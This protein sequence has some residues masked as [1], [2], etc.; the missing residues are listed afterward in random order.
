MS[1]GCGYSPVPDAGSFRLHWQHRKPY[2][3]ENIVMMCLSIDQSTNQSVE[4]PSNLG[5][6]PAG[7]CFMPWFFVCT[8]CV[9]PCHSSSN[10]PFAFALSCSSGPDGS[11]SA[12]HQLA[13]AFLLLFIESLDGALSLMLS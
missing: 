1:G 10:L 8:D 3:G 12:A 7:G 13:R 6:R 2:C 4:I 9:P 11:F 5:G